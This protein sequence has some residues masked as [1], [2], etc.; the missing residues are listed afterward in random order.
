MTIRD[1]VNDTPPLAHEV[2]ELLIVGTMW[3]SSHSTSGMHYLAAFSKLEAA[4]SVANMFRAVTAQRHEAISE[5]SAHQPTA[6][7]W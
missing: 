5:F 6:G 3:L 1:D 4:G 7:S 2:V